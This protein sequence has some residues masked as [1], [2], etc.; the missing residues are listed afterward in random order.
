M[1]AFIPVSTYAQVSLSAFVNFEGAQTNPIRLSADQTRLYAV[2]TPDARLSVFDV[3]QPSNAPVLLAEIPV[4]IEPVSVNPR[5]NDEV[6]VVNQESDS[7]SIVSVSQG[8]VTDTIYVKDEPAD[9]VF[10]GSNLAFVSVARSNLIA[11]FDTTTHA[12]VASIPVFGGAPRAMAVSADGSKVYAV[13]SISGNQTTIVPDYEAPAPPPP[14]NPALPPAPQVGLIVS[15]TD[16]SWSSFIKYSMPDNDVVAINTTALTVSSYYSGVGTINFG[17]AVRPG[18]GAL[19]V[20]NTD[21]RNLIRFEPNLQGHWIDNRIARITPSG[22]VT[23]YDLNPRIDYT[24]LPNPTALTTALSQ[25]TSLVFDPG[26]QFLYVAAFGTDRVAKVGAGGNILSILE[27]GPATGSQVM[28]SKKRGP[29]GLAL[30]AGASRLYVLNRISNTISIINTATSK[31]TGEITTGSFDPTPTVIRQ[32]RGFLYDA[33][34]S[35]NGT[36]ACASC[37]VDAE[38][39]MLAWDLGIPNGNMQTV[40]QNGNTYQMHPMKGPMT[41]R[42]L[43]GLAGNTPYHWRG[44]NANFAAFNP[45]FSTLMGGTQLS[46]AAM[47]AYTAFINTIS[48]QPNP[49]QNLDRSLS[50]S[51]DGGNAVNGQNDFLNVS[52]H[53][54][55]GDSCNSCHKST[56]GPGSDLNIVQRPNL[57]QPM[58]VPVL[59]DIYQKLTFSNQPGSLTIGGFGLGNDGQLAGLIELIQQPILGVF[60]SDPQG[61]LDVAAFLMSFDTG[62]APAV[63]YTRTVTP[64]NVNSSS[65]TSDWALLQNQAVAGN[66]DLIAKG[67]IN[68]KVHGLLYQVATNNYETDTTGLGP[69]TQAQL[70]ADITAGDTLSV[71]GVPVGSGVRMGIDRNLDGIL[72]GDQ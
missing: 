19:Y 57:S 41:T 59:L 63:G 14:T 39:D 52:L 68:G 61:Q 7:V 15:S 60:A 53:G 36:G 13:F 65:I 3:S 26:G 70:I 45:A 21:S 58:R 72:D 20:S 56:P 47:S 28:P 71:M 66:I 12:L 33:K 40:V 50:T 37:H 25:P 1:L 67:T 55:P 43:R 54:P 10:A 42:T 23:E 46:N 32:G 17:I 22:Q 11:V 38:M 44:D 35:G 51:L 16:P 31:V 18:T 29:R 49:N 34:L 62:M 48:Y 6:W 4:G 8:I 24:V 5:T 30:N 64:A 27:I 2:N 9:V 69:F